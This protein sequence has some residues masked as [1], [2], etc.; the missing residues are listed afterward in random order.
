MCKFVWEY[1]RKV[2]ETRMKQEVDQNLSWNHALMWSELPNL[3]QEI[4]EVKEVR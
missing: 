2:I 1:S 3:I 4:G